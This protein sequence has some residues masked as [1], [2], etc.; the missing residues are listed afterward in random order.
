MVRFQKNSM[1]TS[2]E[3]MMLAQLLRDMIDRGEIGVAKEPTFFQYPSG[4]GLLPSTTSYSLVDERVARM[5]E[6]RGDY[7]EL[8]SGIRRAP[9]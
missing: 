8:E 5:Y 7:A 4:Y 6:G 1:P 3:D 2:G 9:R